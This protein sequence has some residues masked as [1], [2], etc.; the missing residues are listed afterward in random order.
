MTRAKLAVPVALAL[1]WALVWL[2]TLPFGDFPLNDDWVYARAVQSLLETG[3]LQIL[4]WS[5][6][7]AAAQIY[8]GALFCEVFGFSHQSLRFA[9][10]VLGAVGVV[11]TYGLLRELRAA[12]GVAALGALVVGCNPLYLSQ[13]VTFM[14]DIPFAAAITVSLWLFAS[15]IRRERPR[16]AMAAYGV[17]LLAVLIRQFAVVLP[18]AFAA[19]V[20]RRR[21]LSLGLAAA[22]LLSLLLFVALHLGFQRWM[23]ATHR[24]SGF[25]SP[26]SGFLHLDVA[27]ARERLRT[28]LLPLAGLLGMALL[29]FAVI[30]PCRLW[31]DDGRTQW[32]ARGATVALAGALLL[33]LSVKH[34]VPPLLGNVLRPFGIGPLTLYDTY[35]LQ[36]SLPQFPGAAGF[37]WLVSAGACWGAATGS[38]AALSL[39]VAL[40]RGRREERPAQAAALLG[41]AAC[42]GGAVLAFGAIAP[43]F[44]RYLIPLLP[45]LVAMVV[46]AAEGD[47]RHAAELAAAGMAVAAMAVFSVLSTHDWLAWQRSRWE[48]V[49]FLEARSIPANKIDGGYEFNGM[50]TYRPGPP[51]QSG[52]QGWWVED[53]EYVL[54]AGPRDGYREIANFG[55]DAW[56]WRNGEQIL[57]LQ[58]NQPDGQLR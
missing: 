43:L 24:T 2:A 29:P 33:A 42:Y 7:N 53:D 17:G 47:R 27:A 41:F 14:T 38:M 20:L 11:A 39:G 50:T 49:R 5:A 32:L 18:V 12:V 46:L 37:W 28:S 35:Q 8:W 34:E 45:P 15:S 22:L 6:A 48:A 51:N 52:K 55:V 58:R 19:G 57:V 26:V 9:T 13:S 4:P 36:R 31:R 30:D 23:V 21:R 25:E 56:L 40:V 54:A 16:L 3:R 10:A 44:D 1:G